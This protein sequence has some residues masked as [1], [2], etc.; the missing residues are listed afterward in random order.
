V[1]DGAPVL[2]AS[3]GDDDLLQLGDGRTGWHFPRDAQGNHDGEPADDKEAIARLEA[4]RA[5]GANYLVIPEPSFW[6]LDHY[7]EFREHLEGRY[8]LIVRQD[9]VCAIYSLRESP[10][11]NGQSGKSI[12]KEQQQAASGLSR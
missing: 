10:E 5:K 3:G 4:L 8:R 11:P 1:P 6:W 2:V 12:R 9:D 7:K